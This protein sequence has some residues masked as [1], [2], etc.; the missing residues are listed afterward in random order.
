MA[1]TFATDLQ[2]TDTSTE[3]L[4]SPIP[5]WNRTDNALPKENQKMTNMKNITSMTCLDLLHFTMMETQ[6]SQHTRR[7]YGDAIKRLPNAY[8]RNRLEDIQMD[9][10]DFQARFQGGMRRM[11]NR[12]KWNSRAPSVDLFFIFQILAEVE[13]T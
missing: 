4:N 11:K 3:I 10:S 12:T 13:K 5:K 6:K 1:H 7:D 2:L 8:G 9:L